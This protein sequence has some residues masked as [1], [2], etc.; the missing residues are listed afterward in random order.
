MR[1]LSFVRRRSAPEEEKP[2][3]NSLCPDARSFI[4]Q[5]TIAQHA[6]FI[7][8]PNGFPRSWSTVR[9]KSVKKCSKEWLKLL[10]EK[11]ELESCMSKLE[12]QRDRIS[13]DVL[14]SLFLRYK[15][16]LESLSPTHQEIEIELE[17]IRKRASE[18]ID[19]LEKELKPIQERLEEFRSLNKS[20]A[21]TSPIFFGRRGN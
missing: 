4:K 13:G 18:E 19:D 5:G 16:R 12:A 3:V 10:E 14:N 17:S 8:A 7:D 6:V 21:M 15:E 9:K 1:K 20:G 2:K 11:E